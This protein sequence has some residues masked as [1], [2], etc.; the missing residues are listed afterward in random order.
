MCAVAVILFVLLS[1]GLLLT[2]PPVGKKIFMS[3][4]TSI[5]AI[6]V[7]AVVFAILYGIFSESAD[8]VV[9]R[10]TGQPGEQCSTKGNKNYPSC[11]KCKSKKNTCSA[12]MTECVCR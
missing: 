12:M 1:P 2:I 5:I 6:L 8:T 9:T 10:W 7:H 11:S 3:G 4:Q